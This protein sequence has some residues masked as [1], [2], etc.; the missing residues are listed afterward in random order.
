MAFANTRSEAATS[1]FPAYHRPPVIQEKNCRN[2][3]HVAYHFENCFVFTTLV[4]HLDVRAAIVFERWRFC[5]FVKPS[6]YRVGRLFCQSR[7]LPPAAVVLV[8]LDILLFRWCC[9]LF[10]A[11][12]SG[13][14][15]G[16]VMDF[17]LLVKWN[18]S[19]SGPI[20]ERLLRLS[21]FNCL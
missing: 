19:F 20:T 5:T 3:L 17:D 14:F 15:L 4:L 16:V 10:N 11:F 7:P 13:V 21:E 18:L 12:R 6:S 1:P 9:R 8:K 2:H